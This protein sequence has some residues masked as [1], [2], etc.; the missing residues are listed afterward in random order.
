MK[1]VVLTAC[2]AALFSMTAFAQDDQ[3]LKADKAP[4]PPHKIDD[5]YRGTED[6]RTMT[7][8]DAKEMHDG[9]SVSLRG[10]LVKKQGDDE[11][12]FRDKTDEIVVFIPV[13]VFEGKTMSP[14]ELVGISGSLD[15]KQQPA[16]VK[17]THFRK[18]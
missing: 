18:E 8:K 14:D 12:L 3:N 1:K 2:V 5:G 17:V 4:P 13:A 10:N 15:K 16:R 6:A 11:Y 9:A 7:V